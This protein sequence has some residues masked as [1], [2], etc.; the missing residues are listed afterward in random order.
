MV[1]AHIAAADRAAMISLALT[2][3]RCARQQR[4][5]AREAWG[6]GDADQGNNHAAKARTLFRAAREH[7]SRARMIDVPAVKERKAA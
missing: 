7:I 2:Q 4:V 5:W 1:P 3:L 6:K